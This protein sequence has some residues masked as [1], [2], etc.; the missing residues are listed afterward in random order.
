MLRLAP[1]VCFPRHAEPTEILEDRRLEFRPTARP[2]DVLDAQQEPPA[3]RARHVVIEQRGERVPQVEISVGAGREAK[4]RWRHRRWKVRRALLDEGFFTLPA[5]RS[6]PSSGAS[7]VSSPG[8][9]PASPAS[10]ERASLPHATRSKCPSSST[11][12]RI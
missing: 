12:S 8:S 11:P 4:D 9:A 2:I 1:H 5:I 7:P 6:Y 3:S 10:R